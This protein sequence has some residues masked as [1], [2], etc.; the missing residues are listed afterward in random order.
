VSQIGNAKEGG[1][2]LISDSAPELSIIIPSFNEELRLPVTLEKVAR[3]IK[4]ERR[5]TEVL[6]VD[7]GS[8]DRTA[9]VAET[10]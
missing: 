4:R 7:D 10:F 5:N 2:D 9:E 8:T 6:G 1:V 3:F